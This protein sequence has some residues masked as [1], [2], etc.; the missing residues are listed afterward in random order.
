ML[1][2][3]FAIYF[4]KKNTN[5]CKHRFDVGGCVG[6]FFRMLS[7]KIHSTHPPK[8]VHR[9]T[10]VTNCEFYCCL[11]GDLLEISSA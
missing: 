6:F 2:G 4:L 3:L 10:N 5:V 1:A 8:N 11:G 7:H 9:P